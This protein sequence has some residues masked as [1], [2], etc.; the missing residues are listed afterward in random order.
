MRKEEWLESLEAMLVFAIPL[1]LAIPFYIL[2][3]L[4]QPS[5]NVIVY[6]LYI[7]LSIA[8]TKHNRR[9]LGEIGITRAQ[10]LPCLGNSVVLVLASLA[11][12]YMGADLRLSPDLS[13]W[14]AVVYNLFFWSLSGTG[15]EIVFRGLIL[16]SLDR[17]KGWKVALTVSSVLFGLVHLLRYPSLL[18]MALEIILGVAWGWMT[19]KYRNVLGPIVAHSLFNF[20]FS[21]ALIS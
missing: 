12:R 15:Q 14:Q 8:V 18:A 4:D 20:M 19:L 6:S 17:W 5:A 2:G 11:T 10:L 9:T 16:F 7:V 21:F 1:L 3:L 13:S